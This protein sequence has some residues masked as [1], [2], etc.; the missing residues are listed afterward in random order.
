MDGLADNT[1]FSSA[2]DRELITNTTLMVRLATLLYGLQSEA[3]LFDLVF[4]FRV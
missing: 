2:P 3:F 4:L 1:V